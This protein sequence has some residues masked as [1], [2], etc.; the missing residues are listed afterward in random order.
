MRVAFHVSLLHLFAQQ[1]PLHM[2]RIDIRFVATVAANE[3]R[4]ARY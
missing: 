1:R 3:E 4:R 2:A